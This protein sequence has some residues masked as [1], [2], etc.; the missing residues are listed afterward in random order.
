MEFWWWR[1]GRGR[2]V[3]AVEEEEE[4]DADDAAVVV[5]ANVLLDVCKSR[6]KKSRLVLSGVESNL[7]N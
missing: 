7:L 5:P 3:E 6:P 2:L 1:G 4:D